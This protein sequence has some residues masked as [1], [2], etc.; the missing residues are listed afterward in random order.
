[1]RVL[2]VEDDEN[3]ARFL[4]LNLESECFIVDTAFDGE[5]GSLLGRTNE[6]DVI[7]LDNMLPKKCG[8]EVCIDIRRQGKTTP[9]LMLSALLETEM[10][11]D[12]LN[13][14]ADDYLTKPFSLD[15]LLARVRALLRRP[16]SFVGDVLRLDNVVMDINRHLV[17]RRGEM[18]PLTRKE[19][20]LLEYLMRNTGIVVS[21]ASIMDHVWD[22]YADPFSN[23][24]ES[25]ILSVRKKIDTVCERKLIHTISGCGYTMDV[26]G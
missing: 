3:M 19:F 23:T 24:I 4:K 7:V 15:E 9:I 22:M 17:T 20:I 26:R 14:G 5:E 10:K 8:K 13:T 12:L 25:H 1:M 16:K 18:V 6:Y 21:R 2:V 11:T